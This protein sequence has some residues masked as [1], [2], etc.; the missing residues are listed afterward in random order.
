MRGKGRGARLS[1]IVLWRKSAGSPDGSQRRR[2]GIHCS[3]NG[4]ALGKLLPVQPY[5]SVME[6]T[7]NYNKLLL[8]ILTEAESL[9]FELGVLVA[10]HYPL[11]DH[12]RA[13]AVQ[14]NQRRTK[15]L[16][17]TFAHYLLVKDKYPNAGDH[18]GGW[19]TSHL[20]ALHPDRVDL[21]T[22]PEKGKP[23]IGIGFSI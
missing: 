7:L 14:F 4:I 16:A 22:L 17:W 20:I 10:G 19:E 13:A 9:G 1:S 5:F 15:M 6:Q 21:K 2:P 11:I 18:A 8:H 12:C 3:A 23:L